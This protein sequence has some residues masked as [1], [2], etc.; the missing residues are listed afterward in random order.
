MVNSFD[1]NDGMGFEEWLEGV[2]WKLWKVFDL[3]GWSWWSTDGQPPTPK[4]IKDK[5]LSLVG[6]LLDDPSATY[7]ETGRIRVMLDREGG[8]LSIYVDMDSFF[9]EEIEEEVDLFADWSVG[10]D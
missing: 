9:S 2:S 8:E 1:L 7:C 4:E 10:C 6:Y 3:F 5:I